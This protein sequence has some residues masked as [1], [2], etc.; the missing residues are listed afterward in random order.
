M[1]I[2]KRIKKLNLPETEFVVIGSGTMDA[3]GIRMSD[4]IDIVASQDLYVKLQASGEWGEKEQYGKIFLTKEMESV[5]VDSGI[6]WPGYQKSFQEIF[7][8]S[9]VID[10]VHFMNLEEL[11][12]F[13]TSLGREKDFAD[14]KLIEEYLRKNP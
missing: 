9:I 2:I 14:I 3:L 4:D 6:G 7:N 12:K 11:K 1:N 13:K 8:S 10:G 5:E